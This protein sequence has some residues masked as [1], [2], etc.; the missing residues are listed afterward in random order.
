M[1]SEL[2]LVERDLGNAFYIENVILRP[3]SPSSILLR[4]TV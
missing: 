2:V 4:V 1:S 3:F